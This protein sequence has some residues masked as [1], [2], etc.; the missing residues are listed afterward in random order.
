MEIL[1]K[2]QEQQDKADKLFVEAELASRVFL[3]MAEDE[4]LSRREF[5]TPA[6]VYRATGGRRSS[7]PGCKSE[8]TLFRS[9]F[10]DHGRSYG[11]L[12]AFNFFHEFKSCLTVFPCRNA[13]ADH[14][15]RE[16]AHCRFPKTGSIRRKFLLEIRTSAIIE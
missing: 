6:D 16:P 2:L 10:V 15:R 9:E 11:D 14:S 13:Q 1:Q 5:R 12:N 7:M 4:G 8:Q 3:Q